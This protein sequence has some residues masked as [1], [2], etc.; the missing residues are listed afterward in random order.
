VAVSR[1]LIEFERFDTDEVEDALASLP[2]GAWMNIEPI[3]ETD[4][5]DEMRARLPHPLLRV[6]SAKGRPIP[7]GTVVA[8][9][10]GLAVGLEHS[11]GARVVPELRELGITVP[12]SWR[13]QQDHAKR[14]VVYLAPRDEQPKVIVDWIL[15]A[16]SVLTDVPIRGNWSAMIATP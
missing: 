8:Q 16:A 14:G 9:Q 2:D 6:F 11:R 5:L 7:F 15:A 1:R 13:Q 12:A 3:I 10:D 4:D